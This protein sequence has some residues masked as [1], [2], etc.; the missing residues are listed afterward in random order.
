[1]MPTSNPKI[2]MKQPFKIGVCENST[3]RLTLSQTSP[4]FYM[5]AV[6]AFWKTLWEKEKLLV[7]SN[8]SIS[9]SVFYLLGEYS[10]I[11]I[12]FEI[13]VCK[14]FLFGRVLHLSFGKGLR[15]CCGYN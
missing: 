11:F 15:V 8:F 13:V 2:A 5:S 12:K 9:H 4:S 1:M 6:Q 14:L 7:T 10:A 3:A